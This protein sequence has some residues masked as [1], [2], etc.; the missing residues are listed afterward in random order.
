MRERDDRQQDRVTA[1]ED[2]IYFGRGVE[3]KGRLTFD[4]TIRI[5]GRLEGEIHTEGTI[6]VGET[7]VLEGLIHTG[8]LISHGTVK[9]TITATNKVDLLKASVLIGEIDTPVLSIEEGAHLQ[10]FCNKGDCGCAERED[11]DRGGPVEP[12]A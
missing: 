3:F 9:G 10:G 12:S 7:G 11:Q 5:D 2:V 6:E 8:T 4:G 1:K